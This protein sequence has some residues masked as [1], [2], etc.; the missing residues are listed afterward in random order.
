MKHLRKLV[1]VGVMPMVA[2]A[3]CAGSESGAGSATPTPDARLSARIAAGD[4]QT[5]PT[6][7]APQHSA[8]RPAICEAV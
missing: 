8:D 5:S 3:G 4:L 6:L 7:R 2:A 1:P